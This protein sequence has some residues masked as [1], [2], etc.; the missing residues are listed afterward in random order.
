M[1]EY[2]HF[3]TSVAHSM[4]T[5]IIHTTLSSSFVLSTATRTTEAKQTATFGGPPSFIPSS[6]QSTLFINT[7]DSEFGDKAVPESKSDTLC[8]VGPLLGAIAGL[9]LLAFFM[10]YCIRQMNKPKMTYPYYRRPD[11]KTICYVKDPEPAMLAAYVSA[12]TPTPVKEKRLTSDTLVGSWSSAAF[13]SQYSPQLA[14]SP[15]L[16]AGQIKEDCT[17]PTLKPEPTLSPS[18]TLIDK[19][20]WVLCSSLDNHQTKLNIYEPQLF[21]DDRDNDGRH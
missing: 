14:L 15:S 11:P 20:D 18:N 8:F 2:S 12:T 17:Q 19:S 4:T 13:K 10:M 5:H 7:N 6:T 9:G 1:S 21:Y 16:F 3:Y